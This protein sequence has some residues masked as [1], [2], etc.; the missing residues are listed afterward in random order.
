M[1]D[2]TG[3]ILVVGGGIVSIAAFY[4]VLRLIGALA[5][6]APEHGWLRQLEDQ[7]SG[8]PDWGAKRWATFGGVVSWG[9]ALL[10]LGR[11]ALETP[12]SYEILQDED[13]IVATV[14][15]M[16]WNV[17]EF[18]LETQEG[19]LIFAPPPPRME[20]WL[21]GD[22]QDARLFCLWQRFANEA[23]DITVHFKRDSF[24]LKERD[25]DCDLV[26]LTDLPEL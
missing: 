6:S 14:D 17:T 16:G 10:M 21:Y 8:L 25:L 23:L 4:V 9:F 26:N 20:V 19:N 24:A 22:R 12:V 18:T 3:L 1:D 15:R 2:A 11:D 5:R 7:L 13:E